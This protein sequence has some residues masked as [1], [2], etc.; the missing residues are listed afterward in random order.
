MIY[1]ILNVADSGFWIY[2]IPDSGIYSILD[3]LAGD[4]NIP[5][6][7]KYQRAAPST[8]PRRD[9][10]VG[11]SAKFISR[12]CS[13]GLGECLREVNHSECKDNK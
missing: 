10:L 1:R 4:K 7:P 12:N 9:V 2:R 13:E 3:S 5:A 6:R 11:I 8:D